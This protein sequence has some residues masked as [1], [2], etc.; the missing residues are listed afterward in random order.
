MIAVMISIVTAI[1]AQNTHTVKSGSYQLTLLSEIQRES[2]LDNLIGLTPQII[3]DVAPNNRYPGA[4]NAF[5]IRTEKKEHILVDTGLGRELFN[6]LNSMG[7]SPEIIDAILITHLHG[8]HF[9]GLVKDGVAAFKNAKLYISA[10]EFRSASDA[11]KKAIAQ[12]TDRL[13][14]FEPGEQ[15]PEELAFGISS[16]ASYGHTP[17]HTVFI[18][19]DIL[20]WGDLTHAMA[21]QM[22]YPRVAI[23]YDTNPAMAIESRIRVLEYVI[24]NNLTV[25]GMHIPFPGIG[26]VSHNGR[27]GYI[28]SPSK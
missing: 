6:N 14:L 8:D 20:I 24:Q 1:S 3:A 21:I 18:V 25:A 12:Y 19:G 2:N 26:S 28:F 11:A 5:L 4:L 16:M 7:V 10:E 17:G 22:P 9:G 23:T 27:G 15:S 13:I